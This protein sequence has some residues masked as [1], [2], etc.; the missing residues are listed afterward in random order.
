VPSQATIRFL[1]RTE[2]GGIVTEDERA[3]GTGLD[4]EI[5]FPEYL[6]RLV[7]RR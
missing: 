4:H 3:H 7:D 2:D 1:Q 5:V 6:E